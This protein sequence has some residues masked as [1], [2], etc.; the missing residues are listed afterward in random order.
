MGR[1]VEEVTEE[2]ER[3]QV[4]RLG[5]M[6]RAQRAGVRA[7]GRPG[8]PAGAPLPGLWLG[9]QLFPK[10]ILTRFPGHSPVHGRAEQKEDDNKYQR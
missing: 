4:S 9:A 3:G 2:A 5:K 10:R 1:Q 8:L 6:P 7:R